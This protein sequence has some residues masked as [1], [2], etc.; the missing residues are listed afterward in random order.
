MMH[1]PVS[2][3]CASMVVLE[4][5]YALL[6]TAVLLSYGTYS[7]SR[8]Q[9]PRVLWWNGGFGGFGPRPGNGCLSLASVVC[10]QVEVTA[11]G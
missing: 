1:G 9:W 6:T 10:F 11:S 7:V 3:R 4:R 2:I 8:S 5:L